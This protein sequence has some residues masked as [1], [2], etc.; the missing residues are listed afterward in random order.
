MNVAINGFG[1]I[2]S[3]VFKICLDRNVNVV[4]I[5][6]LCDPKILSHIIKYDSVYGKYSKEVSYGEDWIKV[7]SKKIKVL[8][9]ENPGQLPWKKLKVDVVVECTGKFK[10]RKEALRHVNAGAKKVLVSAPGKGLDKTIVPGVN[11]EKLKKKH[12]TISVA[13]CTTNALAPVVKVLNDKFGI[14]KGF[15]TTVHAYTSSQYLIDG[16]NKKIRR[17]RAAAVN[18]VPT[19]SGATKAVVEVIP[20]LRGRLDGVALRVPVSCGSIVDFVGVLKKNTDAKSVNEV[21][22][23]AAEKEMKGI[24]EYSDEELVSSDI[25]GNKHSSIVSGIDTQVLKNNLVKVLAWYDNE[26]GYSNRM[27]DIIKR[28]R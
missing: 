23:K 18:I 12:R 24:I 21:L 13:S 16:P 14:E 5:N 26:F 8:N 9:E 15:M 7:G 4:A 2:G 19:T 3:H 1:R 28:L 25:I 22:K 20:E 6:D 27:V 17:G 10:D 11:L